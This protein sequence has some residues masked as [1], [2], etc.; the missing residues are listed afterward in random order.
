M[1][2]VRRFK[3]EDGNVVMCRGDEYPGGEFIHV[4]D[5]ELLLREEIRQ[6]EN[7]I[8]T[9]PPLDENSSEW[10]KK[11]DYSLRD[12]IELLGHLFGKLCHGK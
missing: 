11:F 1:E 4:N 2:K 9:K 5:I 3:I 12:K 10:D 6:F 8:K 7:M